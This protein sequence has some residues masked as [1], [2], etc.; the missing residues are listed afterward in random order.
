M[1]KLRALLSLL[2]LA[3]GLSG[4]V[5]EAPYPAYGY[6]SYQPG[7]GYG[8]GYAPSYNLGFSYYGGGYGHWHHDHW[9]DWH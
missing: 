7:Y 6:P 8:Y 5:Y 3:A 9:H 1:S 4:C 2:V